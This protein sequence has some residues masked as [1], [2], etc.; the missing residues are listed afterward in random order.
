ML[1]ITPLYNA[2]SG[3]HGKYQPYLYEITDTQDLSNPR[4]ITIWENI[5]DKNVKSIN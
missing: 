3:Q 1:G 5:F 2:K 4:T